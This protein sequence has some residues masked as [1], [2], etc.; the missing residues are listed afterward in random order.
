MRSRRSTVSRA[1]LAMVASLGS[2]RRRIIRSRIISAATLS[3][4]G[5]ADRRVMPVLA[6]I[7]P[8]HPVIAERA[9]RRAY[10]KR[11]LVGADRVA[12]IRPHLPARMHG[13]QRID[14]H[15]QDVR[16]FSRSLLAINPIGNR[17]L[18]HPQVLGNQWR[19]SRHR[20]AGSAGE[21]GNERLSL[22]FVST[23]VNVDANRPITFA[24][25]PWGVNCEGHVE[26]VERHVAIP[27]VL[28]MEDHTD[29]ADPLGRPRGQRRR[30]RHETWTNDAAIAV[31]E[32]VSGEMPLSCHCYPPRRLP[33]AIL[34]TTSFRR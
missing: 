26:A 27:A 16:D 23:F 9:P 8:S 12:G 21:H 22:F 3:M 20:P 2:P 15:V 14:R 6:G 11:Q 29:I 17:H 28:D 1:A 13:W 5:P 33:M 31:L 4:I 34:N 32:V 19:E 24:H 30:L 10:G 7:I 18:L 25:R